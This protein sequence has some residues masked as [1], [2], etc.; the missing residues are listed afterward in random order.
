[1]V[2]EEDEEIWRAA[3]FVAGSESSW[4]YRLQWRGDELEFQ[5]SDCGNVWEERLSVG[6][7]ER[8]LAA[9]NESMEGVQ[10]ATA[11]TALLRS[12]LDGS[13]KTRAT[14]ATDRRL[15]SIVADLASFPLHWHFRLRPG[16]VAQSLTIPLLRTLAA[17]SRLLHRLAHHIPHLTATETSF[18]FP[19]WS[20][21]VLDS[22]VSWNEANKVDLTARKPRLTSI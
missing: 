5:L 8:R 16:D 6:E 17:S 4:L 2:G 9:E 3:E 13:R 12:M 11:A 15:L 14:L 20:Q 19:R 10:G 22:A 18:S 21:E 1:M 7:L